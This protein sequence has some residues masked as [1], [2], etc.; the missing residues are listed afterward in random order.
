[1]LNDSP[2][3]AWIE[4]D[5][6]YDTV[7]CSFR[8]NNLPDS[9]NSNV[10]VQL[11]PQ[12]PLAT[13]N[14]GGTSSSGKCT[15]PLNADVIAD[16]LAPTRAVPSWMACEEEGTCWTGTA[17]ENTRGIEHRD[18]LDSKERPYVVI[19]VDCASDILL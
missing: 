9:G 6:V 5:G 16:I 1:M 12:V 19:S 18:S 14:A 17:E 11:P 3:Q 4:S 2:W 7:S 10:A 15:L 8:R 13:T